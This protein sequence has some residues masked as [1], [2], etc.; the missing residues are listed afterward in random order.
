MWILEI[1]IEGLWAFLEV[2]V[3]RLLFRRKQ[4]GK[5]KPWSRKEWYTQVLY[6]ILFIA[7]GFLAWYCFL[8]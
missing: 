6:L 8:G 3:W 7:A 5:Q 4:L 1:L 2:H